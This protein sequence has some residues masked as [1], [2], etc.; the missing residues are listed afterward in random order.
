MALAKAEGAWEKLDLVVEE[1]KELKLLTETLQSQLDEAKRQPKAMMPGTETMEHDLTGKMMKIFLAC[2]EPA[3]DG[4]KQ[5]ATLAVTFSQVNDERLKKIGRR[6]ESALQDSATACRLLAAALTAFRAARTTKASDSDKEMLEFVVQYFGHV[7]FD[8]EQERVVTSQTL[9]PVN[10]QVD[11]QA[12]KETEKRM[13]LKES[14]LPAST[15]AL[16]FWAPPGFTGSLPPGTQVFNAHGPFPP[17]FT[18]APY[19]VSLGG[20]SQNT[21]RNRGGGSR[22]A[23]QDNQMPPHYTLTEN[24]LAN[25]AFNSG[26][27]KSFNSSKSTGRGVHFDR[28]Y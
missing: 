3:M 24:T 14:P 28:T 15:P 10:L 19:T 7:Q 9:L 27:K 21:S 5:L 18:P 2:F 4:A 12:R 17:G 25:T 1:N 22:W 6:M 11:N 8:A 26:E 23:P 20:T 13:H 16:P